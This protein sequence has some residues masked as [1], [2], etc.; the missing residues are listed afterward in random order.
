MGTTLSAK[1]CPKCRKIYGFSFYSDNP[2][3]ERLE[4]Y[5]S[6]I[7]T[8]PKCQT[9]FLDREYKEMM[10]EGFKYKKL[11]PLVYIIGAIGA[12][13]GISACI[14]GDDVSSGLIVSAIS[15]GSVPFAVLWHKRRLKFLAKEAA[16]SLERMRNPKYAAA[17]KEYG[18]SVPDEYLTCSEA[19]DIDPSVKKILDWMGSHRSKIFYGDLAS[20]NA[21][22]TSLAK[23][24]FGEMTE[25]NIKF[26]YEMY[27]ETWIRSHGGFNAYFS[28]P[29][30]IKEALLKKY[31]KA[32]PTFLS[33]CIECSLAEIYRREPELKEQADLVDCLS[34]E[35][36]DN[37][38]KNS[39]I[40]DLYINDPQYGLS[41]LKP[42]FVNGFGDDKEYLS[43][44]YT[45]DGTKL[46]FERICSINVEE[47]AGPV[48]EYRLL[49]PDNTEFAH[50]FICNYGTKT[51]QRAPQNMK[52]IS[53]ML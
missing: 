33:K 43:H 41:R 11:G 31:D 49:L 14:S 16:R 29:T 15:V 50:I 26:C 1:R 45:E 22:L 5:G 23:E 40:E 32:D 13:W 52:Y 34:K 10:V 44:L 37:A 46:S 47:I 42:V 53:P 12:L 25:E 28:T 19:S 48:D 7:K 21:I 2:A 39:A 24:V 3:D 51:P 4:K 6:P 36:Q 27:L 8:C 18:Y 9:V 17:L 20:A 38:S 30:Y 35:I